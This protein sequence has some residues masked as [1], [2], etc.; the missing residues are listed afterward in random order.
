[1]SSSSA[2]RNAILLLIYNG[3]TWAN[4]AD[5]AGT[6]PLTNLYFAFH[7]GDPG[8]AGD[9][10]TSECAYTGYSRVAVARSSG[11][12]TVTANS[13]SPVADVAFPEATAGD[14]LITH[15][16]VGF[17]SSGGGAIIDSGTVTPNIP[18]VAGVI[19]RL[20]YTTTI[21]RN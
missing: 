16:S 10:T 3:T 19:P 8:A 17:L 13:V 6:A 1:M 15:F 11:G 12:F 21:T 14:E 18:V 9:Q 4:I 20:R 5:N 7:T 2:A